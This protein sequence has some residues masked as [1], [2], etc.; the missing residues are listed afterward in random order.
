MGLTSR[1][2]LTDRP[3]DWIARRA[4]SRPAPG[5]LTYTSTLRMPCSMAFLAASEA[6]SWAA[7]GVPLRDPLKP[8]TPAADHDTTF[9]A[10]SVMVTRV[11]LKVALM[12]ATPVGIFLR[13]FFF[14]VAGRLAI[15]VPYAFFRRPTTERRGPFRV[16]A[17][18]CVRWPLTG[19]PRR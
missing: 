19:R 8:W 18:V 13:S 2:R 6:A 5:P 15:M 12:W 14:L 16:R 17:L 1:I 9:P 4:A 11:L 7:K 3:A 10:G